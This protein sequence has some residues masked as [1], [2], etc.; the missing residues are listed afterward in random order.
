M[1]EGMPQAIRPR[2]VLIDDDPLVRAGLK[3]LLGGPDGVEV[4]AEGEDGDQAADLV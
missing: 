4:V 3:M 2:V 1:S